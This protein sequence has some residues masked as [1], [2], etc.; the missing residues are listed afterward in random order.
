MVDYGYI[1]NDR[2]H[3]EG[4]RVK[5]D[6]R[7]NTHTYKELAAYGEELSG[8]KAKLNRKTQEGHRVE[9]VRDMNTNEIKDYRIRYH[10]NQGLSFVNRETGKSVSALT[11]NFYAYKNRVKNWLKSLF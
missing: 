7:D 4:S 11:I 6:L 8:N 10:V 1:F 2:D 3:I 9:A 5:V